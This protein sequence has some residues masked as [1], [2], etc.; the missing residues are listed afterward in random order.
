VA[1][2]FRKAFL[3]PMPPE[4]DYSVVGVPE[5]VKHKVNGLLVAPN[6]SEQLAEG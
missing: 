4:D 5:L 2:E 6:D 3:D 1:S